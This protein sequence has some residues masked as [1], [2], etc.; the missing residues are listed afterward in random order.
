MEWLSL[1]V[2]LVLALVALRVVGFLLGVL[3]TLVIGMVVGLVARG[4]L[5]DERKPGVLSAAQAGALGSFVA[6]LLAWTVWRGHGFLGVMVLQIV[7]AAGAVA[8]L[9]SKDKAR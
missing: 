3:W 5:S 7:A 6:E 8:L 9:A 4:M 2:V 1:I